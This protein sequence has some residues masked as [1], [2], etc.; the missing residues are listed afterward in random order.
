[1]SD[2]V[3]EPRSKSTR[4]IGMLIAISKAVAAIDRRDAEAVR[5]GDR[6]LVYITDAHVVKPAFFPGGDIGRLAIS[7]TV[8]D[9]A[10]AGA[11]AQYLSVGFVLEEGLPMGTLWRVVQSMQE[12]AQKAGV[13][14]LTGDTKVVDRAKGDGVFI[15]TTGLGLIPS[16]SAGT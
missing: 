12:A 9:L 13:N 8:N 4:V 1:M 11:R 5:V 15:N 14:I 16:M 6:W 2:G 3:K 7:G 10:M